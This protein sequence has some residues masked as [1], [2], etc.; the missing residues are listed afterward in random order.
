MRSPLASSR[1]SRNSGRSI[2]LVVSRSLDRWVILQRPMISNMRAQSTTCGMFLEQSRRRRADALW[3]LAYRQ[4]LL[5]KEYRV[6]LIS[7]EE[8]SSERYTVLSILIS[9]LEIILAR[10][11]H[12]KPENDRLTKGSLGSLLGCGIRRISCCLLSLE[13]AASYPSLSFLYSGILA[14]SKSPHTVI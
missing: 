5:S 6:I 2:Q 4:R 10:N 13:V 1:K 9:F 8:T 14:L 7:S 3:V 12:W 11:K